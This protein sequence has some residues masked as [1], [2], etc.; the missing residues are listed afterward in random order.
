VSERLA[1]L[2]DEDLSFADFLRRDCSD[3]SHDQRASVTAYVEGFDAADPEVVSA[4]WL[5]ESDRETGQAEG[6]RRVRNGY[7]QVFDYFT[8][9]T[10]G[11][12]FDIRLERPVTSIRWGRH[13]VEL[14]TA[15]GAACEASVARA[16]IITLPLG[17]L[18]AP[19][20]TSG[21]VRFLPD[22]TEK[23]AVWDELRM[24]HVVKLVVLFRTPFWAK[25]GFA[26]LTFLHTPASPFV[27]WWTALPSQA[28]LLTG[29]SGGPRV[30]QLSGL[31]PAATLDAGLAAL[32]ESFQIR[33][34][35]L[36]QSVER[37]EVFDWQAD[38]FSRGAYAYV[39]AGGLD[40]PERLG[41]PVDD[42]LF[43]AGEA[44]HAT[45]TGTVAGAI[46]SGTRAAAEVMTALG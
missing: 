17:V 21:A 14:E 36:R 16:A 19:P 35:E 1:R 23:R 34:N 3:L 37:W 30:L 45:L 38:P 44:T 9:Q 40:L 24:G 32:A 6:A 25:R 5:R 12:S 26:D 18:Q 22:V 31:S 2:G 33:Q 13:R 39:P 11:R 7:D 46:A 41:A 8:T 15:G 42:T 4:V 29:W 27:A 43:F 28:P 10:A 20:G